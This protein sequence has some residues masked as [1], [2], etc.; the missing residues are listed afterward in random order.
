MVKINLYNPFGDFI[1]TKV[2]KIENI[3]TEDTIG[4]L[5]IPEIILSIDPSRITSNIDTKREILKKII[6]F[7]E[8]YGEI[9]LSVMDLKE[10]EEDKGYQYELYSIISP[11]LKK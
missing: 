6:K 1:A 11:K 5:N 9:N 3:K 10:K 7:I 2:F 8:E 4:I